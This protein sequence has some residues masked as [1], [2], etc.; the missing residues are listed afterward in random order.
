MVKSTHEWFAAQD[1]RTFIIERSS[2]AGMGKYGS[3]WLGDNFSE[4][5]SMAYSVSGI[6]LMNM[7]GITLSGSDICGFIGNTTDE[8]C[9]KWHVVGSFYPFSRNHNNWGQTPQEPYLYKGKTIGED[10]KDILGIMRDSIK[11]KYSLIRYYYTQMFLVSTQNI[12]TFFKPVFFEFPDDPKAFNEQIY[13]VMLGDSL[14]LSINPRQL[15]LAQKDYYFPAGVWCGI[16]GTDNADGILGKCI[17]SPKGQTITY[18]AQ[19]WDYQLHIRQGKIVPLQTDVM[20]KKFSTSVEIQSWPV[21]LHV[22][23]AVDLNNNW[24]AEGTYVNDDGVTLKYQGKFN[25]YLFRAVSAPSLS[26]KVDQVAKNTGKGSVD[27]CN[28]VNTNDFL[29]SIYFYNS[30][31][32]LLNQAYTVQAI[33]V[34]NATPTDIGKA[35]YDSVTDRL[36]FTAEKVICLTDLKELKFTKSQ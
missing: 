12:G 29:Q 25:Q 26:F 9:T 16:S 13:N 2:F 28:D 17:S 21:D 3:R 36:V 10:K 15:K 18:P 1:R 31:S 22:L 7:F 11:R 34:S 24:S 5:K 23:G 19:A 27:N 14:K 20:T 33:M 35:S 4:D 32:L 8:L 30:K 6:M